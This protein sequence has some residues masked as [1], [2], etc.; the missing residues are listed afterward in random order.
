MRKAL[1]VKQAD[2]IGAHST[3]RRTE[4]HRGKTEGRERKKKKS[5]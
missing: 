3:Q 4:R 1:V 5:R 2:Q